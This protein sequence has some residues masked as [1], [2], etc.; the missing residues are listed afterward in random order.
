MSTSDPADVA[1]QRLAAFDARVEA[2][3]D[4]VRAR[5][6]SAVLVGSRATFAWL[7]LGGLNH[8]VAGAEGG[9][10]PVLVSLDGV[11]ALAPVNEAARIAEEEV[12]GLPIEVR[13][14]PWSEPGAIGAEARELAGGAVL[15]EP[16]LGADLAVARSHLGPVEHER[17]RALAADVAAVLEDAVGAVAPGIREHE[18]AGRVA[19]ALLA[20]GA[21]T[22]VLLAAADDRIE[23]YRH[24]IPTDTAAQRRI[25]VVVVAERW[26]IHAAA[27]R[28]AELE[29]LSDDLR[30]R[31][32]A[33]AEVLEAMARATR[34]GAT[35]GAVLDA[36]REAYRATGF[37]DEWELHHQGGTIGYAPR[38]RIAVPGDAT[39]LAAGMAVAWN[40]S[41]TG[42]KL[43]STMIVGADGVERLPG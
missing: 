42:T 9:A 4:A 26:G 34:P 43:E 38:E 23:R 30:S 17:M 12:V 32:A 1:A 6:G 18:V 19:G 11:W 8:V 3:R 15:S 10:V 40:P 29:P 13:A 39:T 2:V 24:P 41:I 31:E 25:M 14:L 16:D 5:G 33:V 28:F 7:T 21:R 22:P 20:V 36:A 35:L 27:T 37:P